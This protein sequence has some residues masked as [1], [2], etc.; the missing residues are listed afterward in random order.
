MG[1]IYHITSFA[2][3]FKCI[4]R[5]IKNNLLK[6]MVYNEHENCETKNIIT[7]EKGKQKEHVFVQLIHKKRKI[8][9]KCV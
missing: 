6:N 1:T 5:T 7:N 2:R 9:L 8:A 4:E 3:N